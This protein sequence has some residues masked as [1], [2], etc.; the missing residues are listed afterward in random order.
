MSHFT[1]EQLLQGMRNA[2]AILETRKI[3]VKIVKFD[4]DGHFDERR[5]VLRLPR[6]LEIAFDAA[7]IH[8]S[9]TR[10]D[11]PLMVALAARFA[12][13]MVVEVTIRPDQRL[14]S[15][16]DVR[17]A[18]FLDEIEK[19]PERII[20]PGV[21]DEAPPVDYALVEKA[22]KAVHDFQVEVDRL[23]VKERELEKEYRASNPQ[24]DWS[25]GRHDPRSLKC[26]MRHSSAEDEDEKRY[27]LLSS[28]FSQLYEGGISVCG[29]GGH[30]A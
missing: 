5:G 8:P 29:C 15:F 22:V 30:K 6:A 21:R 9:T 26:A 23:I 10:V 13:D 18:F 7:H 25:E 20:V 2:I 11:S 24:Q 17:D 4:I 1:T 16:S 27:R 12:P 14:G 28:A 19:H 3:A